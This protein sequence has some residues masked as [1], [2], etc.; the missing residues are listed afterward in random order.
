MTIYSYSSI[1]APQTFVAGTDKLSFDGDQPPTDFLITLFDYPDASPGYNDLQIVHLVR[2]GT[3]TYSDGRV[4][5]LGTVPG[6]IVSSNFTWATGGTLVLGDNDRS[7]SDGDSD[8]GANAINGTD[9]AD[10][11]IGMGGSDTVQGRAGDDVIQIDG[12]NSVFAV[13][14]VDGG[15]GF[16]RLLYGNGFQGTPALYVNLAT[17]QAIGGAGHE[18]TVIGIEAVG[19]STASDTLIGG[20]EANL[21]DG[22]AGGDLL[23][24]S[25][26]D[27][28]LSGEGGYDHLYGGSGRDSLDGG[29]G[30]DTMVGSGGQDIYVVTQGDVIVE[31]P[32]EGVDLVITRGNWTMHANVEKLVVLGASR[33]SITG[34]AE[35]NAITG[36]DSMTTVL[37]GDGDDT[38]WGNGAGD[39]LSGGDGDDKLIGGDGDDTLSGDAGADSLIGGNGNDLLYVVDSDAQIAGGAGTD[40]L[41]L[42]ISGV[43]F[44][45][46]PLGNLAGSLI[47]SIEMMDLTGSGNATLDITPSDV[48]ALN[49]ADSLT[50]KGN[51]GDVV[52][53]IGWT[54]TGDHELIGAVYYDRYEQGGA[55]M[56]IDEDITADVI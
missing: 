12:T 29:E 40:T 18:S 8:A 44:G 30:T 39:N 35:S 37:A 33:S 27:D 1:S 55:V 47:T 56:L 2:E 25:G 11:L 14:S 43:I 5:L 4:Y 50:I 53:S 21:F 10:N 54:Q 41:K 34:N 49:T 46:T 6:A 19:G 28:T 32:G 13:Y 15:P 23:R 52:N 20:A 36:N 17:H 51:T 3:Y 9:F 22:S 26:G 38:V 45:S 48:E 16:D 42:Q 31:A 24:G 7:D